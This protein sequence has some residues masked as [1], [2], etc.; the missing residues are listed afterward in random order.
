MGEELNADELKADDEWQLL[1]TDDEAGDDEK[2][3]GGGEARGRGFGDSAAGE[4]YRHS[5]TPTVSC[6]PLL[7]KPWP[8]RRASYRLS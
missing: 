4:L 2:K 8:R 3:D 7:S 1:L 5:A 6:V